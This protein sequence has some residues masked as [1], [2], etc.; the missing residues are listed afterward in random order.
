MIGNSVRR[1]NRFWLAHAIV[2]CDHEIEGVA[3]NVGGEVNMLVEIK[4]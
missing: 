1:E 4:G 2:G 3:V